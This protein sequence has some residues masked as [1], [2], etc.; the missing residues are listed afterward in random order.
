MTDV[1]TFQNYRALAAAIV[2]MACADYIDARIVAER[3][4]ISSARLRKRIFDMLIDYGA[5]RYVYRE[6]KTNSLKRGSEGNNKRK[7]A[8]I[9]QYYPEQRKAL[10]AAK[11]VELEAFFRSG[12]FALYMPNTDPEWVINNLR[13]RAK[14][15]KRMQTKYSPE[16]TE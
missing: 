6:K 1:A 14:H 8:T 9:R 11:A 16:F 12:T 13:K 4:Y 10:G 5:K 3:G 2:E 15:Y 7:L